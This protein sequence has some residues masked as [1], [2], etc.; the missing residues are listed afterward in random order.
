MVPGGICTRG[1]SAAGGPGAL[2]PASWQ[3]EPG[4]AGGGGPSTAVDGM[5]FLR[6]D[7]ELHITLFGMAEA[8]LRP[9][10]ADDPAS[11]ALSQGR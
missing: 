5:E 9:T 8:E 10:G 4:A 11:A 2:L 6:H 3:A 7:T 1:G